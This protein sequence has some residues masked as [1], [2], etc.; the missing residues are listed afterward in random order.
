[1][2]TLKQARKAMKFMAGK[3]LTLEQSKKAM[4][5]S[6]GIKNIKKN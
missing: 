3:K 5:I 4:D 6:R 1:M 2:I